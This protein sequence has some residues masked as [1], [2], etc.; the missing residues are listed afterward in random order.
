[1]YLVVDLEMT[2]TEAGYH[3][4]IEIGAV[5]CDEHWCETG[6]FES[7]VYPDNEETFSTAAEEIHGISIYD[8]EDAPQSYDVLMQMEEWIRKKLKR[9]KQDSLRDVLVCGQSVMNDI[10]FLKLKYNS[11]HLEWPF[12]YRLID[13]VTVSTWMFLFY[14]RTGRKR[15]SS[16]SLTAVAAH[17]GWSRSN[18]AHHAIE[19]AALTRA[20]FEAFYRQ[21]DRIEWKG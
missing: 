1:M 3:D 12:A 6:R 16:Y 17:F 20:C 14:D 5:L 11:L 13:L 4:I 2:G 18:T 8:L 15:P 19:D 7:L 10:H 21:L 9:E